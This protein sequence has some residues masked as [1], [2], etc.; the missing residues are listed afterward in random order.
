MG[1][2]FMHLNP[3]EV[4]RKGISCDMISFFQNQHAFAGRESPLGK[5]SAE[6]SGSDNQIIVMHFC[7]SFPID[8]SV[9]LL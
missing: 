5:H 7:F 4:L 3:F 8:V 2:I 9:I 1:A 6:K